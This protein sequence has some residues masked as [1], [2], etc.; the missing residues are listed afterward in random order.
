MPISAWRWRSTCSGAARPDLRHPGDVG[1][2]RWRAGRGT[3]SARRRSSRAKGAAFPID[4]RYGSA[5]RQAIE[6]AMARAIGDAHWR[7][8]SQ[9]A[10]L[11]A[12]PARKSTAP[13]SGWKAGLGPIPT[14]C[15][16][17]EC[18][19]QKAQDAAIRPAPEG[20][21]KIVLATSIAETSITIDGVRVVVDSGLARLPKF[22]ARHRSHA[23]GNG[24]GLA[25][26]RRPARRPRRTYPT[27]CRH[28]SL[29][30]RADRGTD[31]LHAAARSW[32]PICRDWCSTAPPLA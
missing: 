18:S 14:S 13:P 26:L 7:M 31:R 8:S 28:T 23:A 9:P 30:R 6:E 25:R 2:A 16:S 22:E 5:G 17:M 27:G 29:A 10:C 1:H 24:A 20:Q 11:P 21:R 32:K 15:R 3:C 4:I 19:T 12:G